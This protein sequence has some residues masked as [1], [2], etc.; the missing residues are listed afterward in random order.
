MDSLK[1]VHS[2]ITAIFEYDKSTKAFVN[3]Y[4][5]NTAYPN[6]PFPTEDDK[7]LKTGDFNGDGKTDFLYYNTSSW[8]I[9]YSTGTDYNIQNATNLWFFHNYNPGWCSIMSEPERG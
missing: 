5:G 7:F 3:L 8:Y 9:A 4:G 1:V 2:H 6:K